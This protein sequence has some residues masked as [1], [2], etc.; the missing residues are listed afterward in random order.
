MKTAVL[1]I[2][3]AVFLL[4]VRAFGIVETSV[5]VPMSD[6]VKLYADVVMPDASGGPWPVILARTPYTDLDA[7]QGMI[8]DA[9]E[10]VVNLGF[11][12]MIQHTRGAGQSEGGGACRSS[13]IG[14]TGRTRWIG[15]WTSPGA[16]DA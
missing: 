5:S 1:S 11:A 2:L 10:M 9:L 13:T 3:M 16:T 15:S 12:T 6:G 7:E 4:P 8:R 14:P